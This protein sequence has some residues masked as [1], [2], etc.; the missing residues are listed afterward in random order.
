MATID[1]VKDLIDKLHNASWGPA[2]QGEWI[3]NLICMYGMMQHEKLLL[4]ASM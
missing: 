1:K 3:I 2:I 4:K